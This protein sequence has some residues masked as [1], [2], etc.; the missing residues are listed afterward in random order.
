VKSAV[1]HVATDTGV[2]LQIVNPFIVSDLATNQAGVVTAGSIQLPTTA[3]VNI[4]HFEFLNAIGTPRVVARLAADGFSK[5]GVEGID[6]GVIVPTTGATYSI[7]ALFAQVPFSGLSTSITVKF[8]IY[9]ASSEM[10]TGLD[11]GVSL[12]IK[13]DVTSS[14]ETNVASTLSTKDASIYGPVSNTIVVPVDVTGVPVLTFDYSTTIIGN[15]VHVAVLPYADSTYDSTRKIAGI[16]MSVSGTGEQKTATASISASQVFPVGV[17]DVF[18]QFWLYDDNGDAEPTDITVHIVKPKAIL[19]TQTRNQSI[20]RD[21]HSATLRPVLALNYITADSLE[22]WNLRVVALPASTESYV[23]DG[24]SNLPGITGLAVTVDRTVYDGDATHGDGYGMQVLVTPIFATLFPT[25]TGTVLY[26]LWAIDGAGPAK[27]LTA[28]PLA[29][30]DHV[31]ITSVQDNQSSA[32][33]ASGYDNQY[34]V[35]MYP[36]FDTETKVGTKTMIQV[37]KVTL[38]GG[39]LKNNG[40]TNPYTA[41]VYEVDNE[42]SSGVTQLK[43]RNGIVAKVD[44]E[45][46]YVYFDVTDGVASTRD[47]TKTTL[48]TITIFGSDGTTAGFTLNVVSVSEPDVIFSYVTAFDNKF[49]SYSVASDATLYDV[50]IG[51]LSLPANPYTHTFL[52][53]GDPYDDYSGSS[54]VYAVVNKSITPSDNSI[55]LPSSISVIE[56]SRTFSL[57]INVRYWVYVLDGTPDA[58]IESTVKYYPQLLADTTS[59][60]LK[61]IQ[62]GAEFTYTAAI[63]NIENLGGLSSEGASFVF[64]DDDVLGKSVTLEYNVGPTP[65]HARDGKTFGKV[66]IAITNSVGGISTHEVKFTALSVPEFSFTYIDSQLYDDDVHAFPLGT[67]VNNLDVGYIEITNGRSGY[68]ITFQWSGGG[69]SI[70]D[71]AEEG[72]PTYKVTATD[73]SASYTLFN[74]NASN[75]TITENELIFSPLSTPFEFYAYPQLTISISTYDAITSI[76]Q[77][78]LADSTVQVS[79]TNGLGD[80]TINTTP[81]KSTVAVGNLGLL[82]YDAA[83]T[84]T[85]AS[86][87]I[88]S[89]GLSPDTVTVDA[90]PDMSTVLTPP[91][92]GRSTYARFTFSAVAK[93]GIATVAS[94][95]TDA[96][97]VV[98]ADQVGILAGYALANAD[99]IYLDTASETPFIVLPHNAYISGGYLTGTA[100]V[101]LVEK[102]QVVGNDAV[103]LGPAETHFEV[104]S[105]NDDGVTS[106]RIMLKSST[107]QQ[108]NAANTLET[109]EITV[110]DGNGGKVSKTYYV[111]WFAAPT[112][113]VAQ[114]Q[115]A[116]SRLTTLG[117]NTNGRIYRR[118]TTDGMDRFVFGDDVEADFEG[119]MNAIQLVH[120]TLSATTV[121]SATYMSGLNSNTFVPVDVSGWTFTL[122]SREGTS[123]AYVQVDIPTLAVLDNTRQYRL[124]LT[125]KPIGIVGGQILAVADG[126]FE[127]T[128]DSDNGEKMVYQ[129]FVLADREPLAINPA[130]GT[131]ST[132]NTSTLTNALVNGAATATV[133]GVVLVD[134]SP[135]SDAS[136]FVL[137]DATTLFAY[138]T[139]MHNDI[140][141]LFVVDAPASF[142]AYEFQIYQESEVG[143]PPQELVHFY[144]ASGS[145]TSHVVLTK[146]LIEDSANDVLAIATT[147]A[148]TVSYNDSNPAAAKYVL[149]IVQLAANIEVKTYEYPIWLA[150]TTLVTNSVLAHKQ[151]V[152]AY[153]MPDCT[154]L[155]VTITPSSFSDGTTFKYSLRCR[156]NGADTW[157]ELASGTKTLADISALL[158]N[159]NTEGAGWPERLVSTSD[160]VDYS[161]TAAWLEYALYV[162]NEYSYDAGLVA[163][164][165]SYGA[166]VSN[167]LRTADGTPGQYRDFRVPGSSTLHRISVLDNDVLHAGTSYPSVA[168]P[169]LASYTTVDG[170]SVAGPVPTLLTNLLT[171]NPALSAAPV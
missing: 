106:Y 134:C 18:V 171:F 165:D 114:D 150:N 130:S 167:V 103:T 131:F 89:R 117:R 148:S 38:V 158:T 37:A 149:R 26:N 34:N 159:S 28:T 170:A 74:G 144:G 4:L 42:N 123:T 104:E 13:K 169:I 65:Q 14:S 16:T 88:V 54:G 35:L 85:S 72:N 17:D 47:G 23:Y 43:S 39:L 156:A 33:Y 164:T 11:S 91:L 32:V 139:I 66:A 5:T 29:I 146:E 40:V 64:N 58:P 20:V 7:Q 151:S 12:T 55:T 168:V 68:P 126:V 46:L 97:L 122:N 143:T 102:T 128:T 141:P 62:L 145:L 163:S 112:L 83:A 93:V 147:T 120:A 142:D 124:N 129:N 96:D 48:C 99:S 115:V 25:A 98:Y 137:R 79:V 82:D 161:V 21:W 22:R 9:D 51:T 77:D 8:W 132:T 15:N 90:I 94:T 101:S 53:L 140:N 121:T 81:S 2:V 69:Y 67:G 63:S 61:T 155:A 73:I 76:A 1:T 108:T 60:T 138:Q 49:H 27:K 107:L 110:T 152:Q 160:D 80:Y 57:S 92:A 135:A 166:V 162:Q 36:T 78:S 70:E 125:A 133:D 31:L 86:G 50:S 119:G 154:R 56:N 24:V 153:E 157:Y 118:S 105:S 30:V 109:L 111:R 59:V 127:S 45:A 113:N 41:S 84:I 52:S 95:P 100:G 6:M 3:T 136:S 116:L 71:V 19:V 10:P 44:G 75:L 87:V